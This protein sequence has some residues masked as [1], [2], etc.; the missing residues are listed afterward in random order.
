MNYQ[1]NEQEWMI[2]SNFANAVKK[3]WKQRNAQW[4]QV[5]KYLDETIEDKQWL[6]KFINA[7]NKVENKTKRCRHSFYYKEKV[8]RTKKRKHSN[9]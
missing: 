5:Y 2:A 9:K 4:F 3:L 7:I 8:K 6:S 1:L